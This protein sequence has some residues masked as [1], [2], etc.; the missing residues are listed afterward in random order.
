[1]AVAYSHAELRT[2]ADA[3]KARRFRMALIERGVYAG[4]GDRYFVSAGMTDQDLQLGLDRIDDALSS[5]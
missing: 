4:R 5:L 3:D 1:M 2:T